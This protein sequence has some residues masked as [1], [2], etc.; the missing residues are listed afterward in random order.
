MAGGKGHFYQGRGITPPSFFRDKNMKMLN[1]H[2]AVL[3]FLILYLSD[4][5]FIQ[6]MCISGL[7][8]HL[9]GVKRLLKPVGSIYVPSDG[10]IIYRLAETTNSL[11]HTGNLYWWTFTVLSISFWLFKIAGLLFAEGF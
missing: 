6:M 4:E 11:K 8:I 10:K 1:V 7:A 9:L 3:F 5:I 2:A